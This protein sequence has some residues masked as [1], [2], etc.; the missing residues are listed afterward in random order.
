MECLR[1]P[2]FTAITGPVWAHRGS[3]IAK[4][5]DESPTTAGGR[6]NLWQL[7][8]KRR[9]LLVTSQRLLTEFSALNQR[10]LGAPPPPPPAPH[11]E[12][13]MCI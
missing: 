1:K 8:D 11:P 9:R 2:F 7:T 4:V 13:V 6:P 3:C 12:E 10:I 5:V